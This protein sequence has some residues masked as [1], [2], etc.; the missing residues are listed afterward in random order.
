MR[1]RD[2]V[3]IYQPSYV[4]D[5]AEIGEHTKIAAFCDI[6]KD[7]KI[8]RGCN[9]QCHVNLPNGTEVGD[10][11]FLGPKV[12]VA[13]DLYMNMMIQPVKIGKHCR[14]GLGTLINAGV[15]IGDNVFIGMGGLI[16]KDVP[17]GSKVVGK[18]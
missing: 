18:W 11:S 2:K 16:T 7:V 3:V 8:G 15:T 10:G 6:G 5:S 14:I 17:S 1:E 13:N 9:I 12:G 4:H